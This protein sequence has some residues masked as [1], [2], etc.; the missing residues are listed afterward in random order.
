M[1]KTL[2]PKK[3]RKPSNV[4]LGLSTKPVIS[5]AKRG[6]ES[7]ALRRYFLNQN[8]A[9]LTSYRDALLRYARELHP[10]RRAGREHCPTGLIKPQG[11]L[12]EEGHCHL[13]LPGSEQAC[14]R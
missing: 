9:L 12:G 10:T 14:V 2:Q 8:R 1:L 4:F 13:H 11:S 5:I 7:L 3:P 6:I